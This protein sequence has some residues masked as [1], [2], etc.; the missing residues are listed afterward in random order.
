VG[1]LF[2]LLSRGEGVR[3]WGS[4]DSTNYSIIYQ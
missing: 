3:G 2:P 1:C 4:H